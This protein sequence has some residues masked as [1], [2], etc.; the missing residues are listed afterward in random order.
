[1]WAK[2][3]V[4]FFAG[5]LLVEQ[6]QAMTHSGCK[7]FQNMTGC[8]MSLNLL[9]VPC[10][11]QSLTS[12]TFMHSVPLKKSGCNNMWHLPSPIVACVMKVVLILPF[13]VLHMVCGAR[14]G[15][16]GWMMWK[17]GREKKEKQQKT[18]T[19]TL[20]GKCHLSGTHSTQRRNTLSVHPYCVSLA[21]GE[22][23]G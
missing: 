12:P 6:G 23:L 2:R 16:I 21:S 11:R 9:S 15:A 1:M 17:V 7:A 8:F 20:A 13:E 4:M 14:R 18:T 19:K 3:G 10:C 5:D 22:G